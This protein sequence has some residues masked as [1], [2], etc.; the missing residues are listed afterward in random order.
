L[1]VGKATV[2]IGTDSEV[3]RTA[4]GNATVTVGGAY[5][6]VDLG[7]GTN[8][9]NSGSRLSTFKLNGAGQGLTTINGFAP[10]AGN[11]LDLTRTLAG[12]SIA[13]DLSNI[14]KYITS[15]VANGSTSLYV[16]PT[17]GTGTPYAFLSL[18]GVS[19]SVSALVAAHDLKVA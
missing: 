11:V 3:I 16:D 13:S 8:T 5:N 2:N 9:I 18:Q 12:V 17:G 7:T 1:G 14:S 10:T 4:G 19:T 6:L 15:S